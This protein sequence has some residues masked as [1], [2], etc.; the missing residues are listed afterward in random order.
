MWEKI[1]EKGK[2]T[3]EKKIFVVY[4]K[5]NLTTDSHIFCNITA[6]RTTERPEKIV[7]VSSQRN[8]RSGSDLLTRAGQAKRNTNMW[9]TV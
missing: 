3:P 2:M 5:N 7:E 9:V 6:M 8:Q 1:S 4:E